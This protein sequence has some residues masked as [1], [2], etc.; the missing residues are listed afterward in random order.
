MI[1][2]ARSAHTPLQGCGEPRPDLGVE[3]TAGHCGLWLGPVCRELWE[4]HE[5][6]DRQRYTTV[7]AP[8]NAALIS[9]LSFPDG[10]A[11][12]GSDLFVSNSLGTIGAYT[13][14]GATVNAALISGLSAPY[15]LAVVPTVPEPSSAILTLFGLVLAGLTI[16]KIE[17]QWH[18]GSRWAYKSDEKTDAHGPYLPGLVGGR[19][20]RPFFGVW[21]TPIDLDDSLGHSPAVRRIVPRSV[22]NCPVCFVIQNTQTR[23]GSRFSPGRT[24]QP[25]W[26]RTQTVAGLS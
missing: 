21:G 3:Q 5:W 9:G 14:A 8:V 20:L 4:W 11:V 2:V 23:S 18:N 25:G 7:G 13:T 26:L 22:V 10:I 19:P 15:S 17:K 12:S 6:R 1:T 24:C 16:K